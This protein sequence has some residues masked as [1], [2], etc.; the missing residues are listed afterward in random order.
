MKLIICE[1]PAQAREYSNVLSKYTNSEFKKEDG[2][3]IN[4]KDIIISYAIGHLIELAN[5]ELYDQKYKA[6]KIEDLP[7]IPEPFKL[8]ISEGKAKQFKILEGLIKKAEVIYNATDAEREGELIFRYILDKT[9]INQKTKTIKRIWVTDYQYETIVKAYENAKNHDEYYNLYLSAKARSESDWLI[10]INATRT[11]TVASKTNTT[12]TLGRVQTAVL[13]LIVDRY[14]KNK[15]F[16]VEKLYIPF[17]NIDAQNLELVY[18]FNFLNKEDA[19]LVLNDTNQRYVPEIIQE[20]K[21]IKQPVLFSLVDLQVLCNQKYNYNATKTLEL[22]QSLYEKKLISYPRTDSNYLTSALKEDSKQIL[23][24]YKN[25]YAAKINEKIKDSD[26]VNDI[27]SHFIFNDKKTSDHYAIVPLKHNNE[28]YEKLKEDEGNVFIEIIKRFLQ[29]FMN[30]LILDE[31]KIRISITKDQ[32]Y[33]KNFKNIV[34]PG[35]TLLDNKVDKNE[36]FLNIDISK[37][38]NT[39]VNVINKEIKEGKTAPPE[40]FT[41]ATLLKAMKNPLA[42]E[43]IDEN[44]DSVKSLG[45]PATNDQ[46]LPILIKRNYVNFQKKY[47]VPTNLGLNIIE[48]L[49]DTKLN[50]IALTAEIEFQLKNVRNGILSYEKYKEAIK[51]YTQDITEQIKGIAIDV[52]TNVEIDKKE[53]LKCPCCKNGKLYLAQS[54]KNLYCSNYKAEEICNFILY[55]NIAGKK[56]TDKNIVDLLEKKET[57]LLEFTSAKSGHKYKAKIILNKDFKTELNF[58]NK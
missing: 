27:D 7:I 57:K 12:L 18:N 14:L 19:L 10:G 17:I 3:F 58:D 44:R 1:K 30:K 36:D 15:N 38:K 21:E 16:V 35:Y 43:N 47:I 32:F 31:T 13:R 28:S 29:C 8:S 49:K 6:W 52:G 46:F 56:L 40:L 2:Y 33:Y 20:T 24:F 51:K 42:H 5:P 39:Y 25:N 26:F 4:S 34:Y 55:L 54:K 37:I 41:E 50:S 11:L 48:N 53:A 22:A 23:S 9:G 45:T